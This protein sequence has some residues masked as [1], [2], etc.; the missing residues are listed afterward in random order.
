MCILVSPVKCVLSATSPCFITAKPVCKPSKF[1]MHGGMHVRYIDSRFQFMYACNYNRN[2]HIISFFI[3]KLDESTQ[4]RSGRSQM[5]AGD[6]NVCFIAAKPD[7][8]S[9]NSKFII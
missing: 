8:V 9:K 1:V 6:T 2:S 4:N 5:H 3:C 7:S